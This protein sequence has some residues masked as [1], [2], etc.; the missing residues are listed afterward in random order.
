MFQAWYT[1]LEEYLKVPDVMKMMDFCEMLFER[2]IGLYDEYKTQ[3]NHVYRERVSEY[4]KKAPKKMVN[5]HGESY[6]RT[7][8][9]P[10]RIQHVVA[11]PLYAR[12]QQEIIANIAQ[13]N[14]TSRRES[15]FK[16]MYQRQIQ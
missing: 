9:S 2:Q 13:G 15:L 6:S 8:E 7:Q 10:S 3:Y 5:I 1:L 11:P 12:K 16:T 4:F 14:D